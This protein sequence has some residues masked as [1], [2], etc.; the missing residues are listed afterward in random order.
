MLEVA[1]SSLV[2]PLLIALVGSGGALGSFVAFVKLRGDTDS[3]AVSQAQGANEVLLETL[4]SVE[5]ERDYWHA[6]Y[7]ACHGRCNEILAELMALR[8]GERT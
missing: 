5:R 7:D 8:R 4:Q 6:R 3:T 2:A 1:N